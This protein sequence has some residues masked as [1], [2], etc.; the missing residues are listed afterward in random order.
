MDISFDPGFRTYRAYRQTWDHSRFTLTP[1]SLSFGSVAVG[2]SAQLPVTV[3]NPGS[4][5][6]EVDGLAF[7]DP[8][9][10]KAGS[11][12][13]V[14]VPAHGSAV[15]QIRFKPHHPVPFQK[16]GYVRVI[17]SN[18]LFAQ[19]VALSGIGTGTV[20]VESPD[21]GFDLSVTGPNPGR[22]SIQLAFQTP[23]PERVRLEILDVQGRVV[24][25]LMNEILPAGRHERTWSTPDAGLYF[26]RLSSARGSAAVHRFVVI[27]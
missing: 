18:E 4:T 16:T 1:A 5:V 24:A 23:E 15:V 6:L 7:S 19:P 3:H 9:A 20:N 21:S 27:P 2:D 17:T 12:F 26:A 25:Q 22:G 11:S 8:L 10:Y 14:N 13:P